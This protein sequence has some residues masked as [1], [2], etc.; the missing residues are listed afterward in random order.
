MRKNNSINVILR[1]YASGKRQYIIA[2][3]RNGPTLK[4]ENTLL[5]NFTE[6]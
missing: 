2:V 3:E 1:T 4:P 6:Y 5:N